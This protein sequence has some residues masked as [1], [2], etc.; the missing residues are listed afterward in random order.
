MQCATR[1]LAISAPDKFA[2]LRY[3]GLGLEFASTI[4]GGMLIGFGV[5]W[6]FPVLEPFGFLIGGMVGFAASMARLVRFANKWNR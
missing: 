4:L 1:G 3:L 6:L 2:G 5:D